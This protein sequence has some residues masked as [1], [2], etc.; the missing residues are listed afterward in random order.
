[1][2][3]P[4]A[5]M[6]MIGLVLASFVVHSVLTERQAER[7]HRLWL[8]YFHD[9]GQT[10]GARKLEDERCAGNDAPVDSPWS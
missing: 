5:L 9:A 10:D 3:L 8:K 6:L 2:I 4:L 7:G 1:M